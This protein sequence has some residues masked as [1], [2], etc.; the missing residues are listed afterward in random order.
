VDASSLPRWQRRVL[1][2]PRAGPEH[3]S[4]PLHKEGY[5]DEATFGILFI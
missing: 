4:S 1:S 5:F 3:L 2:A